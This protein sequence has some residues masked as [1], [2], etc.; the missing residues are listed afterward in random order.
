MQRYLPSTQNPISLY[1]SPL[2]GGESPSFLGDENEREAMVPFARA[3]VN[4]I[5]LC[6]HSKLMLLTVEST[7]RIARLE[8][9]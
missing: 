7:V 9:G 4:D 6:H 8:V 2:C 3:N 1:F 5:F